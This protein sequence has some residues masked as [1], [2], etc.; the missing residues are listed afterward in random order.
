VVKEVLRQVIATPTPGPTPTPLV[1]T[2]TPGPKQSIVFADLDWESIQIQNAIAR[3]II[4]E[5]YGYPTEAL[6]GEFESLWPALLSGDIDVDM[7][8][9]L[10]RQQQVLDA[11]LDDAAVIPVGRSYADN[12]RSAFVV[13]T[14]LVRENPGLNSIQDI[15]RFKNLFVTADSQGKARLVSCPPDW[16]CGST[17]QQ[18]VRA[19]GLDPVVELVN[20]GS[21]SALFDSLEAAYEKRGPW[22]GYIWGPT[23]IASELELTPLAEPAC[24]PGQSAPAGCAY[25]ADRVNIVVHPSLVSR[26]PEIVAF[27]NNWDLT[28][29]EAGA[30]ELYLEEN[31]VNTEEMAVWYLRNHAS[32]T[33]WVPEEVAQRVQQALNRF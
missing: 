1:V 7:E 20:P 10:P 22:L 31:L 25:P 3:F 23:R 19:Y 9:W 24:R 29:V 12:W 14:Y 13:P 2:P 30:A 15:G 26:A 18:Q 32:W 21:E 11:A 17:N 33:N 16:E 4:E 5:G 28:A 8:V 27:L 6:H